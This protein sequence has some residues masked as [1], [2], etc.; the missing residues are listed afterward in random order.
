MFILDTSWHFDGVFTFTVGP[1]TYPSTVINALDLEYR[2][3][4]DPDPDLCGSWSIPIIQFTFGILQ[5]IA[6]SLGRV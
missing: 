6:E 5:L 3:S 1:G 2:V 4:V